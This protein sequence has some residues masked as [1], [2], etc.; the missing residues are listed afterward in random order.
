MTL[1]VGSRLGIL[2]AILA[3]FSV[4]AFYLWPDR[5]WIGLVCLALAG[6]LAL[7]WGVGE[8][9]QK[10][11]D[12][13][14]SLII[15]ITVGCVVGGIIAVAIWNFYRNS[16]DAQDE[17]VQLSVTCES[18]GLPVSYSGDIYMLTTFGSGGI[19]RLSAGAKNE[20]F[21]PEEGVKGFGYKCTVKNYGAKTAF[22]V[23][24]PITVTEFEW[25]RLEP[26]L[27]GDGKQKKEHTF[28]A[29]IPIPLGPQGSDQFSFYICS[30]DTESSLKVRMPLTGFINSDDPKNK[31]EVT[32]R[33][34]SQINP[35]SVPA[36]L[37]RYGSTPHEEVIPRIT[38][39]S[40]PEKPGSSQYDSTPGASVLVTALTPYRSPVVEME[41]NVPCTF[42]VGL[43]F[44]QGKHVSGTILEELPR[45][46]DNPN[47]IRIKMHMPVK[48]EVDEQ[49]TLQ[50][51][52]K[53][54]RELVMSN[55]RPY[56]GKT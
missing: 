16:S 33:I 39:E 18:V 11:E 9:R 37:M 14:T 50:F 42:I 15:S 21:W 23:S 22:G 45:L 13:T 28:E 38:A 7:M 29:F 46:P 47:L 4:A 12:Q 6:V 41:C 49:L 19:S 53:D 31:R 40:F 43:S 34:A 30:Y 56:L 17:S 24:M 52:S 3:L 20:G 26:A 8:I 54:S 55:I 44:F 5:R 27:W 1:D 36:K 10:M 48:L 25:V 2:G 51:R 32:V 35:L